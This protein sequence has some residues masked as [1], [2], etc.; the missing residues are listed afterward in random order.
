MSDFTFEKDNTCVLE[1]HKKTCVL[2]SNPCFICTHRG[3]VGKW[4]HNICYKDPC[5]FHIFWFK[6]MWAKLTKSASP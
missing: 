1:N 5:Q 3:E 2:D 6:K 4:L